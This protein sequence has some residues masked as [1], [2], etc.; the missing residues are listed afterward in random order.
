MDEL[1]GHDELELGC[2]QP[3][4]ALVFCHS[5]TI[6]NGLRVEIVVRPTSNMG[7]R[8]ETQWPASWVCCQPC[9][10]FR[11]WLWQQL[12][13]GQAEV[14]DSELQMGSGLNFGWIRSDEAGLKCSEDVNKYFWDT[15]WYS[16]R[17]QAIGEFSMKVL[18]CLEWIICTILCFK[19]VLRILV[20]VKVVTAGNL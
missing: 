5:D 2:W 14:A 9:Q 3:G 15:H 7:Q 11:C 8:V 13:A 6:R 4:F 12:P 20:R 1:W 17:T 18:P 19:Q 10:E 16:Y